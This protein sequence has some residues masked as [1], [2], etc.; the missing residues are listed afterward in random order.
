MKKLTSNDMITNEY[1]DTIQINKT[2]TGFD[3]TMT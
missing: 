2:E 3:V 1:E